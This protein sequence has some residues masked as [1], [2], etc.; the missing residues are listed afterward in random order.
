MKHTG[1]AYNFFIFHKRKVHV[2]KSIKT[3]APSSICRSKAALQKMWIQLCEVDV[4]SSLTLG[5]IRST[6]LFRGRGNGA[7]DV[8]PPFLPQC[9]LQK[10][11]ERA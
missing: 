5:D 7:S 1:Y 11:R 8:C 9:S 10:K 3:E 6:M 4:P 2:S